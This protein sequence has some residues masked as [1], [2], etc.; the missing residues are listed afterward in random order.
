MS[1]TISVSDILMLV[2]IL[3]V[4]AGFVTWM[5]KLWREFNNLKSG[6]AY[7]QDDM[8]MIFRCLRIL[9]ETSLCRPENDAAGLLTSTGSLI[10]TLEELNRHIEKRAAGLSTRNKA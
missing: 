6:M 8:V 2:T 10:T 4:I 7:R 3:S 5:F 9:L 1:L